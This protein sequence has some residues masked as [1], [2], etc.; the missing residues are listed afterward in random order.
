MSTNRDPAP[1]DEA[2]GTAPAETRGGDHLAD[3]V[4]TP[5]VYLG[6]ARHTY[7]EACDGFHESL[8]CPAGEGG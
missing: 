1:L 2:G 3:I 4:F 6:P 7:T 5:A 8:A